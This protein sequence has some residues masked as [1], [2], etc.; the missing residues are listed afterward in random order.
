MD[1]LAHCNKLLATIS[2]LSSYS[3]DAL[4]EVEGDLTA[5]LEF[6]QSKINFVPPVYEAPKPIKVIIGQT[7]TR[8]TFTLWEDD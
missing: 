2:Q 1:R 5:I 4:E 8:P 7:V 3:D 6:Y